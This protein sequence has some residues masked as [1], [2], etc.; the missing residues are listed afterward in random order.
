[1][2]RTNRRP[3]IQSGPLSTSSSGYELVYLARTGSPSECNDLKST[4]P[5]KFNVQR[6]MSSNYVEM[7]P[8]SNMCYEN[9]V[10]TIDE[11]YD[12]PRELGGTKAYENVNL[13]LSVGADS[14]GLQ[15]PAHGSTPSSP[16]KIHQ[17]PTPD[18]PPPPAHLAEQSIHLRI[19]PLSEVC[20]IS[21]HRFLLF[22][23]LG[24]F[25]L[26]FLKTDHQFY[27]S[28]NICIRVFKVIIR[29]QSMMS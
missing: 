20:Y 25:S 6:Q 24:F 29:Q 28:F 11:T 5:P 4:T 27:C 16:S 23:D 13:N 7:A 3:Q 19:R 14:D 15:S 8:N 22:F 18:H 21:I 26:I 12:I 9:V 2:G 1:M 10:T 17:P